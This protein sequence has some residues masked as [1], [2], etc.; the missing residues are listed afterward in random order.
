MANKEPVFEIEYSLYGEPK[1]A[2]EYQTWINGLV[3][4]NKK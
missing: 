1:L 2:P 3:V 4:A